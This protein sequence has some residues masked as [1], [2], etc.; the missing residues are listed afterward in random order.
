MPLYLLVNVMSIFGGKKKT[1]VS[2][3]VVPLIGDNEFPDSAKQA[4][5]SYIMTNSKIN[6]NPNSKTI[7][8]AISDAVMNALPNKIRKAGRWVEANISNYAYG[9]VTTTELTNDTVAMNDYFLDWLLTNY[10]VTAT[11]NYLKF[12]ETNN[13]HVSW[14]L[15]KTL[16]GYNVTNNK[17]EVLNAF[18]GVD[19]Y[20]E[21]GEITYC[22]NTI[23]TT[24]DESK[25]DTVGLAYNYGATLT[26][27]EDRNRVIK[28]Y[29]DAVIPN[30]VFTFTFSMQQSS[31][32]TIVK[33]TITSTI[34][35]DTTTTVGTPPSSYV[36]LVTNTVSDIIS[37]VGLIEIRV[38]NKTYD[39]ICEV[40]ED[41]LSYE[42]SGA[43]DETNALDDADME[44]I[45]PNAEDNSVVVD[46]GNPDYFMM[47]FDYVSGGHT[48]TDYFTYKYGSGTNSLL[49]NIFSMGTSLGTYFPRIY[50]RFN[51]RKLNHESLHTTFEYKSSK[52]LCKRMGMDYDYLC[53]EIHNTIG[54]LEHV[55][56]I[57]IA[58]HCPANPKTKEQHEYL[59]E[60]FDHFYN[61]L[62]TLDT[63]PKNKADE[64]F[65]LN[66]ATYNLKNGMYQLYS[67]NVYQQRF[68]FDAVGKK[69][70]TGSIGAVN[71]FNYSKVLIMSA[72][73]FDKSTT[74]AHIYRKQ[75]NTTEYVEI[76]AYELASSELVQSGHVTWANRGSDN[77]L[78]P[79][80]KSIAN[81]L[82][83]RK[84]E[85]LYGHCQM[86]IIN[87][88]Q[89]IKSPWYARTW[90]KVFTFVIAVI[91]ALPSGGQSLTLWAVVYAVATVILIN[92]AVKLTIDLLVNYFGMDEEAAIILANVLAIV[93]GG[94]DTKQL[95]NY[96]SKLMIT[97]AEV[98]KL[99]FEKTMKEL[100]KLSNNIDEGTKMLDEAYALL[101]QTQYVYDPLYSETRG[102]II[103][104]EEVQT[105]LSKMLGIVGITE[106]TVGMP[107]IYTETLLNSGKV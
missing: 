72:A 58:L 48:Y 77:L 91:L 92:V 98:L 88:S 54:S 66:Y 103:Y 62:P 5:F 73:P 12:E 70:I 21:D 90:F 96:F 52:K 35:S 49:D 18:Y 1:V 106:L 17:L 39:Y 42:F 9:A 22:Q 63:V 45:D 44:N 47:S 102:E 69:V 76:V 56:Q 64:T 13:S 50:I 20:L 79:F 99:E 10:G 61:L 101:K 24:I 30:D 23:D 104:G 86:I 46:V 71:S 68:H 34:I 59:Y 27:T 53:D 81:K 93:G 19:C 14:Q 3:A 67:D 29:N 75:I 38:I 55:K 6:I 32:Q 94:F 4:V 16:Y 37:I 83:P 43:I 85:Q 100:E 33:D 57:A 84:R 87:T 74:H 41:F 89:V 36:S 2:T 11:I 8:N 97:Y 82:P 65:R 31:E 107:S 80:E 60:Y 26:R 51:G 40:V 78:V 95:L 105:F 25:L 7:G 15:L 28:P